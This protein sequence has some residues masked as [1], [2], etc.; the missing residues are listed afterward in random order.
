MTFEKKKIDK[1]INYILLDW[2][3]YETWTISPTVESVDK[4][5]YEEPDWEPNPG[6]RR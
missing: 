6:F 2:L 1:Y 3:K 4:N 5:A